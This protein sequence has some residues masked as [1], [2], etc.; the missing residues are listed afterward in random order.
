M[1]TE[2]PIQDDEGHDDPD[3][4]LPAILR[5]RSLILTEEE[6]ENCELQ[7]VTSLPKVSSKDNIPPEPT[8]AAADAGAAAAKE[9]EK[10]AEPE[11]PKGHKVKLCPIWAPTTARGHACYIY[12]FFRNVINSIDSC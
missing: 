6:F 10:L 12:H 8:A 2:Q 1:I 7:S 5:S 9:G 11:K 3:V 4:R